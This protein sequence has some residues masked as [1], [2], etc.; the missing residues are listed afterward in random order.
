MDRKKWGT[1]LIATGV[2]TAVAGVVLRFTGV[3]VAWINQGLA[4]VA[5]VAGMIGLPLAFI[6]S[7]TKP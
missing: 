7:A 6:P 3:D 4:I 1:T 2:V 5:A